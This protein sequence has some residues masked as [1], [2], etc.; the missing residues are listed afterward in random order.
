MASQCI[1][2]VDASSRH[3][4]D[5]AM[6]EWL[7]ETLPLL[8]ECIRQLLDTLWLVWVTPQLPVGDV[9][10]IPYWIQVQR[11]SRPVHDIYAL[12]M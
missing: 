4:S 9:P 2:A 5:Q 10:D 7:G 8:N 11:T 3:A 12:N 1:D 6:D